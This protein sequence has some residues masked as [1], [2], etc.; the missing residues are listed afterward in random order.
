MNNRP[1]STRENCIIGKVNFANTHNCYRMLETYLSMDV[2]IQCLAA[3]TRICGPPFLFQ[4]LNSLEINNQMAKF[5]AA[6]LFLGNHLKRMQ[7]AG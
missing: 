3:F 6:V 4:K 2:Y 7:Q 5:E 1:I